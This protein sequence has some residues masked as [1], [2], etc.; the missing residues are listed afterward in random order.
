M[1]LKKKKKRV[2]TALEPH[3][4]RTR[5][6]LKPIPFEAAITPFPQR[7]RREIQGSH[8]TRTGP[9]RGSARDPH[10][11]RTGP[12]REPLRPPAPATGTPQ[13]LSGSLSR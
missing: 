7:G 3:R 2:K 6:A 5:T 10:G 12:A 13:G 4:T 1:M 8:R 9:A 11:T